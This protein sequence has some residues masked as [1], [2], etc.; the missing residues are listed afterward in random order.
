VMT[1]FAPSQRIDALISR[2]S[3]KWVQFPD[4]NPMSHARTA[5]F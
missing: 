5:L 1:F 2:T 4:Q 3:M